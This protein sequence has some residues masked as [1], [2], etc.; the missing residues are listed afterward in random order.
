MV[1]YGSNLT[2]QTGMALRTL[3]NISRCALRT[4]QDISRCALRTLQ[5]GIFRTK[6]LTTNW[7]LFLKVLR[8]W[9]LGV[10]IF[11]TITF[12]WR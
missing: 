3:Q 5:N 10:E 1:F 12:D 8:L 2:R 11:C 9:V 7:S 4:L 6:V